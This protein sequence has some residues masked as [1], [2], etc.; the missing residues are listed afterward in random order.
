MWRICLLIGVLI[1]VVSTIIHASFRAEHNALINHGSETTATISRINDQRIRLRG[2]NAGFVHVY[3]R[4]TV[5]GVTHNN[6]LEIRSV[7]RYV[8]E[9]IAILYNPDNPSQ[10]T[11]RDRHLVPPASEERG[12]V[13]IV[14]IGWGAFF[15]IWGLKIYFKQRRIHEENSNVS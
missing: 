2:G 12:G 13:L 5:N 10:I 4:Y 15:I 11:A 7:R 6:R 3:V 14:G 8:G 1:I 9:E